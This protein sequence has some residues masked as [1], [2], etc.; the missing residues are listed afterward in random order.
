MERSRPAF[1]RLSAAAFLAIDDHRVGC[2]GKDAAAPAVDA[3]AGRIGVRR[4][5]LRLRRRAA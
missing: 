2:G 5:A 1:A 4:I 3:A